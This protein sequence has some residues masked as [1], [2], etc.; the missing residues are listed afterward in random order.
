MLD[1]SLV[2][3]FSYRCNNL[4]DYLQVSCRLRPLGTTSTQV[5]PRPYRLDSFSLY[6]EYC[7][8]LQL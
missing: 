3:P 1:S 8:Q 4:V 2:T 6:S 5:L 7:V